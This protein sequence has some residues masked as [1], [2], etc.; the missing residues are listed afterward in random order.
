[1]TKPTGRTSV[2]KGARGYAPCGPI[3]ERRAVRFIC[4]LAQRNDKN[5]NLEAMDRLKRNRHRRTRSGN[6]RAGSHR[7][8]DSGAD[9]NV[10][11]KAWNTDTN[12]WWPGRTDG[13]DL[14]Q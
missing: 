4:S 2:V 9:N 12:D 14:G 13:Q 5:D 1:M 3:A 10:L 6:V 11:H 8:V 7:S